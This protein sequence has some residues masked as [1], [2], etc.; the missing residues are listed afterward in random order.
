MW[1]TGIPGY[2]DRR[3]I[4]YTEDSNR[5]LIDYTG[6]SNRGLIDY[7]GN[8]IRGLIDYTG[9]SIRGLI[10]YI[11]NSDRG[12]IHYTENSNR[13][14]IDYTVDSKR[15]LKTIVQPGSQFVYVKEFWLESFKA[16]LSDTILTLKIVEKCSTERC[17]TLIMNG[18][19]GF[20]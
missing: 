15:G 11:E 20:W 5:G 18:V 2:S 8:S 19:M 6:N 14:L 4:D 13:G 9:N 3:L 7:T 17:L 1:S 16:I 12:L 10:H